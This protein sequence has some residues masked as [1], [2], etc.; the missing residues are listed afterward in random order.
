LTQGLHIPI[1]TSSAGSTPNA[2]SLVLYSQI[3]LARPKLLVGWKDASAQGLD[4]VSTS[5]TYSAKFRSQPFNV[6]QKFR[7]AKLRLALGATLAADMEITPTI[8]FDDENANMVLDAVNPTN[9]PSAQRKALYKDT[10]L[11]STKGE[12]NFFLELAWTGTAELPIKF[13]IEIEI[14]TYDNEQTV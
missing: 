6:G 10:Q 5:A 14:E 7:L 4:K 9:F 1:K 12:N 3:G 11:E 13:P 8:Y 2:T